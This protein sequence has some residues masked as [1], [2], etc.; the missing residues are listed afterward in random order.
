VAKRAGKKVVHGGCWKRQ[1]EKS[2]KTVLDFSASLN[3]FPP[4][5]T[6]D[7]DPFYLRHY[8]DDNYLFLKERISHIFHRHPDEI[9]VGNGSIELIRVFCYTVFKQFSTFYTENP[10]FSEYEFSAHLAG[11]KKVQKIGDAGVL[12]ICNPNNPTGSLRSRTAMLSF[13]DNTKGRGRILCADEAFIELSDPA[14]SIVDCHNGDLFVIRSLTKS[15]AVPGIRF[16]YGFGDPDL[17]AR[18]E[19][20]RPPWSVN[21]FAEAFALQA[22]RHYHELE[23]SR[24]LIEQERNWLSEHLLALGLHCRPSAANFFIVD[25]AYKAKVLCRRLKRSGILVRDCTSFGLPTSVRVAVRTRDENKYLLEA[26][27]S[28]LH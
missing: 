5:V 3:P 4:K 19:S 1:Y 7:C 21:A 17:I 13:P 16:G 11:A 6:W 26:L 25:I 28:C 24:R 12:F 18:M 14:Q 9:C 27:A 22:F 23:K 20:V 8:P 15:F 10:T 2:G